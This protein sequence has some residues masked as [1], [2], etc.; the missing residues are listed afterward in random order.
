MGGIATV[1]LI[2]SLVAIPPIPGVLLVF[3]PG[4][5]NVALLPSDVAATA[6]AF[7]LAYILLLGSQA[8]AAAVDFA[9]A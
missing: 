8:F 9:G 4:T 1:F 3:L 7:G 2:T 5:I 6:L